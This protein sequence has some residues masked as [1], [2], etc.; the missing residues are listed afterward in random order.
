M[1]RTFHSRSRRAIALL[2][3]AASLWCAGP[4][5]RA[6]GPAPGAPGRELAAD[7]TAAPAQGGE[8]AADTTAA[9]PAATPDSAAAGRPV[10][11]PIAADT[12]VRDVDYLWVLRTALIE[13]GDIPKL[14]ERAKAMHVRG[15]LVQVVGR[16]DGWY[17]SD[18]LPYPEPL[19][20]PGRDPLGELL[21]L[22]HAAGLEVHAW[23]NCCLVWSGP[24]PPRDPLHVVRA[25][26]EWVAR[27]ADGRPMTR[28]SPRAR[29]RLMV[30]GV[31]LSPG[32]P[33]VRHWIAAIAREI[34]TRYPV[35]G[36]HLDYIRQP[37]I[38]IGFDPTTR[39]RFALEHGAD[40]DPG[41]PGVPFHRLPPGERAAMDSAW[42]AFQQDQVTAIVREVR[43]TLNAVRPGLTLSAAVLADTLTAA[44]RNRQAWSAWLRDS[45]LDRAY[46]MCYAPEVQAVMS[47]LAALASQ[48]GTDRLVPGIAIYNTSPATAAAK[49]KGARALGFPA[50]ALYSYDSLWEHDD[51]WARLRTYL[52]G[53]R[54]LEEQ[55]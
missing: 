36:I 47:Q 45:L 30:E 43:D 4:A 51:L 31:F 52:N 25:H 15:L 9:A 33:G 41:M 13:P 5:A 49:M 23:M 12:T 8:R 35:D 17:R 11:A 29:E 7:T 24:H 19:R 2:A 1:N 28:L 26:P 39:A 37:S 50:I 14:V 6:Q 34:A 54:T 16:G 42:A 10:P 18:L 48:V 3:T 21:P 44:H 20:Q 22:A 40:P 38:G 27:M 32:H 53:P 55:P 46:T